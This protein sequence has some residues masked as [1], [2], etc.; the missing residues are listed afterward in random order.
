MPDDKKLTMKTSEW[1][2]ALWERCRK[3]FQAHDTRIT[4][5]EQGGG[6][7]G[8]VS[9]V[10]GDQESTYRT[11]NVN[12]TPANLGAQVDVGFYIDVQGYL[13]QRIGSDV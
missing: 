5:L 11:G 10:K 1:S 4:A 2:R 12:L 8:A 9:G 3:V 7:G 13:C 6:G